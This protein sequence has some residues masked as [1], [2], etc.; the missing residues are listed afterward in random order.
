M[1]VIFGRKFVRMISFGIGLAT[2]THLIGVKRFSVSLEIVHL[3]Q[4][5]APSKRAL[6]IHLMGTG[7]AVL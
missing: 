6:K 5:V 1:V 4:D 7:Q 3:L 2:S